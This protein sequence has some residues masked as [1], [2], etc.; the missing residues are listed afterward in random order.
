MLKLKTWSVQ[1]QNTNIFLLQW[2]KKWSKHKKIKQ[3]YGVR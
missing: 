1:N 2:S 3:G